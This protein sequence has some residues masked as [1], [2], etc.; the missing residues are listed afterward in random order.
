MRM[1]LLIAMTMM[2]CLLTNTYG[3]EKPEATVVIKVSEDYQKGYIDSC[4]DL[5][6]LIKFNTLEIPA[7]VKMQVT[8]QCNALY[9]QIYSLQYDKQ[10]GE[11]L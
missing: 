1:I 11:Q 3:Q 10:T 5:T 8:M 7:H 9:L 4:V 2:L 6:S